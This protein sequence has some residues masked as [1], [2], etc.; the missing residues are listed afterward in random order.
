MME[1]IHM[2]AA[3][4]NALLVAVIPH[5]TD[6]ARKLDL[7]IELPVTTNQVRRFN[8]SPDRFFVGAGL[9]LT[10]HYWFSFSFGAVEMFRSPDNWFTEQDIVNLER[11]VGKDNMT[12]N[13]AIEL[14]RGSFRKLGYKPEE[15][16]VDGPPTRFEGPPELKRLGHVPYCRVEW[17]SPE[18]I[19]P[20]V[21]HRSHN[22]RFDI[23][24]QRKQVVGMNLSGRPFWQPNPKIDVPTELE[25]DYRKRMKK[26]NPNW[27]PPTSQS[28]TSY[29]SDNGAKAAPMEFKGTGPKMFIR[30]NA[31]QRLPGHAGSPA[32]MTVA[33][34]IKPSSASGSTNA[35]SSMT[36]TGALP[37]P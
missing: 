34:D 21:F 26:E 6:I 13:E 32:P 20:E 23:D 35:P 4:S 17:N 14:A 12:T 5:V 31:A 16:K 19:I 27:R 3:Y 7:P 10:N 15:F 8:P 22:I 37:P 9:G 24:M 36:P 25:S 29:P 11:Y 18:S 33:D 1:I 2:T 30:T 28:Q